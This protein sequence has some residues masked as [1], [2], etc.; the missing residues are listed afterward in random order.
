MGGLL[1]LDTCGILYIRN[2]LLHGEN[3][4]KFTA[5]FILLC[6]LPSLL[7]GCSESQ[8]EIVATTLPVYEFT[9]L[10]CA[11]TGL[12]V[13]Q[14]VTESVSCLH[15]YTLKVSQM[16]MVEA[17]DVIICNG[18][19]LEDFLDDTLTSVGNIIDSSQNCHVHNGEDH[20]HEH[21]HNHEADPHIWLS[22]ANA[23]IMASNI[24]T[25]LTDIYP[26]YT[27]IFAKNLSTLTTKLD[28][29]QAYGEGTLHELSCRE[30]ITFHDGFAYFAESFDL[31]V[32]EAVEEESGSEASAKELKHLITIAM[33][34]Q[35]PAVFVEENGSVSAADVICAETGTQAYKL[36][37]AMAD[38]SYFE[39]MYHNI[40]TIKEAL[41]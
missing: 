18:A 6:T 22:P 8:P 2:L 10:I 41:G 30:L 9:T 37:M 34:R 32:L 33:E 24:C 5:I 16:R 12:S 40:D 39:A 17:A 36:D 19:G 23:K 29:L 15:D 26:Q 35:L 7:A 1:F 11:G 21:A 4:R 28:V 20:S 25:G 3:M 27:E 38:R 31:T 14:L 13:G